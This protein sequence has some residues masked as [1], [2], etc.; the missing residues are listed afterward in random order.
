MRW[1]TGSWTKWWKI[2]GF[3]GVVYGAGS[4]ALSFSPARDLFRTKFSITDAAEFY[5][6]R[7]DAI[8]LVAYFE[9]ILAGVFLLIFSSG[10]RSYL[11]RAEGG[12]LN[13]VTLDS[14][15]GSGRGRHNVSVAPAGEDARSGRTGRLG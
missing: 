5:S 11:S 13:V 8:L 12:V 4:M 14:C 6:D 3:S 7:Q 10:L 1:M 15:S 9:S 2:T